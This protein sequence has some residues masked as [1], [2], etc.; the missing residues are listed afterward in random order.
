[1]AE[2]TTP[3]TPKATII[4][5]ILEVQKGLPEW[6][7]VEKVFPDFAA[8]FVLI[9]NYKGINKLRVGIKS[10]TIDGVQATGDLNQ[11][12]MPLKDFCRI[13]NTVLLVDQNN[14]P[15]IKINTETRPANDDTSKIPTSKYRT[16]DYHTSADPG[17]CILPNTNG[18]PLL[19]EVKN[20]IPSLIEGDPTEILNIL[21]NF[22]LL[23][24]HLKALVDSSKE[25]RTVY[26]LFDPIFASLNDAMGGIN[27]LGFHYEESEQTFYIVD[28]Q[29]QVEK[30]EDLPI[31]NITGLK[32]SVTQ[33]DFTTKLSPAIATM[34]AVSAQASGED[35]G[36]EAEALFKWNE[37]LTDRITTKRKQNVNKTAST[38]AE[39]E[40][41]KQAALKQQQGRIN[42]IT[43]ILNTVWVDKVYNSDD[44][45]N[46][47]IQYQA[48]AA[49]YLQ[50]Y[51]D[52]GK[53]GGP[54]G[55]IPFEVMIEMD[56]IS[57]IKI[58]Q[59]FQINE[60]I[61]P[62]KYYGTI[63]F[64]VTGIEH[65]IANNRWITKLKA[66]TIVLEGA[67]S[68]TVAPDQSVNPI[69]GESNEELQGTDS[70]VTYAPTTNSIVTTNPALDKLKNQICYHESLNSY[71]VANIGGSSKRSAVNVNGINLGALLDKAKLPEFI[72]GKPNTNRVFAS[73]RYQIINKISANTLLSAM[74]GTGLTREDF[75]TSANQE[76]LGDWLILEDSKAVGNYIKGTNAGTSDHLAAAINKIGYVWASAPVVKKNNGKVVGNIE[77]GIGSVANYGGTGAN[78]SKARYSVATIANLL[79]YTRK[80]YTGKSPAF[81]PKYY[82]LG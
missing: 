50:S 31:L 64:I 3:Q 6:S 82:D 44:I 40:T 28:R 41:A 25:Q 38:A 21:V 20:S 77:T 45:K 27:Q 49:Y 63:G 74:N 8:K 55:I 35:V 65:T 67:A 33:F 76:K 46:A 29:V 39:K 16:F 1:M 30:K 79:V 61:M 4:Q 9:N 60:G 18:W 37:G 78:P 13:V 71:S 52:T 80:Q 47:V 2:S 12:Y 7:I 32:S 81:I 42:G 19:E 57:G 56:G 48:Y 58:G 26:N 24:K 53:T 15:I 14:N 68:K 75:Y 10:I 59:A 17:V 66:Q 62:N 54:A 43:K 23:E 73:G 36:L 11:Y 69:T 22:N 34:V 5:A 72:N 70:L 51:K